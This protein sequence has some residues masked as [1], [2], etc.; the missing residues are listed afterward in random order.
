MLRKLFF[1]LC[2]TLPLA[3]CEAGIFANTLAGCAMQPEPTLLP[4]GLPI[5]IA[6][7]PYSVRLEVI[8]TSTPV[9]GIYVSDAHAL[10][11]G[12]WVEH[13]DRDSHGLITGTPLKAGTY[14]VHMSAGTYGTQ[15]TGR[16][17]S[18]VYNLV[19]TE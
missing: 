3:G 5:A 8:N 9:H 11:E 15:C 13:Q 14:E 7:R 2:L 16:R 17:A 4:E 12:L 1:A 18:R 6:G 10:P 19:V